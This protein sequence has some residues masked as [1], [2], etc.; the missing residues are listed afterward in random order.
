MNSVNVIGRLT[1]DPELVTT[2]G[3]TNICKLRLAVDRTRRDG[4]VFLDVK[5]FEGQAR[6]CAEH[7]S[8]GREVAVTGRLELDEWKAED[9]GTRSRLYVIGERVKFLR[10]P[11]QASTEQEHAQEPVAAGAGT[12]GDI[13]F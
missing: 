9:G 5:C 7:L 10:R 4:A 2:A 8:E 12:P 1:R 11:T 13:P 3:G 6:A